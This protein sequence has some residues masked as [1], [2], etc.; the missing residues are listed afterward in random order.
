MRSHEARAA[1]PCALSPC[2]GPSPVAALFSGAGGG[3]RGAARAL[4][5]Q[6]RSDHGSDLFHDGPRSRDT[7]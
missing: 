3:A 6:A 5:N 4:P 1:S 7:M 2:S